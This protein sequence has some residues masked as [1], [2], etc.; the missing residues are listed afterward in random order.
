MRESAMMSE[1]EGRAFDAAQHVQVRSFGGERQCECG[2]RRVAIQSG[3]AEA[4]AGQKVGDG[5]QG[6]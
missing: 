1:S 3:A 4:C 5:F 6:V 2:Q